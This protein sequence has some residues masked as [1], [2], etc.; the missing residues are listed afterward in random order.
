MEF[1]IFFFIFSSPSPPFCLLLHNDT[2]K[3]ARREHIATG[4]QL[5]LT[6][7][8]EGNA[9]VYECVAD[10]HNDLAISHTFTVTVNGGYTTADDDDEAVR[11]ITDWMLK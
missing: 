3:D 11:I 9:G 10:P 1:F 2:G 7:V 8:R 5:H 4:E 6:D